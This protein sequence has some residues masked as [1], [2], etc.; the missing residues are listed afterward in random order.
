M[1]PGRLSRCAL[2][3]SALSFLVAG[4][5][6]GQDAAPHD[7]LDIL[8]E[9]ALPE[10]MRGDF[11][12]YQGLVAMRNGRNVRAREEAEAI[13]ADDPD[14]IE[15]HAL[16]AWV[17]HAAE[18]D[19]ARARHHVDRVLDLFDRA[20]PE[21]PV[22]D[23]P[24][25]WHAM[26]LQLLVRLEAEMG[27]DAA[28]MAALDLQESS[29]GPTSPALR[30]W[31]L[32]R[33]G[34]YED[35]R[36]WAELAL[37]LPDDGGTH[38]IARTSLCAIEA[39]LW[40]R[41]A[42]W[43]SCSDAVENQDFGPDAVVSTNAAEAAL[44]VLRFD[45]AERLARDATGYA[46]DTPS[47]PWAMLIQI[48]LTEGRFAEAAAALPRMLAWY[49]GQPPR[50]RNQMRVY[51]DLN[52]MS[53]LLVTGHLEQAARLSGRALNMPDRH[54]MSNEDIHSRMS[55]LAL[56][57]HQ[58]QRA[59]EERLWERLAAASQFETAWDAL[60]LLPEIA[61]H[62]MAAWASRRRAANWLADERVLEA[63][64]RPYL[65]DGVPI[66]EWQQLE[67]AHALDAGVVEALI[68]R[69]RRVDDWPGTQ[70]YLDALDA[71]LAHVRGD[72]AKARELAASAIR[73]LPQAEVLMRARLLTTLARSED[74]L[75]DAG[76]ALAAW[77]QAWQLDP[78]V[79]RRVAGRLPIRLEADAAGEVGTV[80]RLLRRS[81]RFDERGFGFRLRVDAGTSPRA[82][83]LSPAG[84]LLACASAEAEEGESEAAHARRVVD[85]LHEN[86]FAPRVELAQRD[87]Q[88][89][90]GSTT[91]AGR[92]GDSVRVELDVLAPEPGADGGRPEAS[93][94]P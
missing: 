91:A 35:A 72:V 78:G 44:E 17:L 94:K 68:A 13:L 41:A 20:H 52:A 22:P 59:A 24:W 54:G 79:I 27:H 1:R 16:M 53:L 50:I 58:V 75:G 33:L 60:T 80:A 55:A 39:E 12:A 8:L 93:G 67:L 84:A 34:R 47:S 6:V 69:A 62:R 48:Y 76:A 65:A 38:D 9:G 90:D 10:G 4:P 56:V 19:L 73:S 21:G 57:D 3:C 14:A 43:E 45:D 26:S 49:A 11:R 51:N 86:A 83:L 18:G 37:Q 23:S 82:C 71:E 88:T 31:P 61:E 85:A 89:L 25:Y 81:P 87:L 42:A 74:A 28:T 2:A 32:M 29:Y 66:G 70:S 46:N 64:V 36:R 63:T 5:V 92:A 40:N 7:E 15:G 30:A 77:D